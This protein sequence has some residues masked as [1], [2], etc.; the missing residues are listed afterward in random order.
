MPELKG[1]GNLQKRSKAALVVLSLI[2]VLYLSTVDALLG[3]D[4]AE[5]GKQEVVVVMRGTLVL[6]FMLDSNRLC[7]GLRSL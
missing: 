1:E 2:V 6:C 5:K 4:R 7:C 3:Q